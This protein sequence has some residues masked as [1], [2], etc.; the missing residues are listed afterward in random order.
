ME[1]NRYQKT[2][3]EW[4]QF[5]LET[6]D[7]NLFVAFWSDSKYVSARDGAGVEWLLNRSTT[8]RDIEAGDDGI[9][10]VHHSRLV[11]R[12]CIDSFVRIRPKDGQNGYGVVCV[13]GHDYR[14]ARSYWRSLVTSLGKHN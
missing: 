12:E 5:L 8:L 4:G 1:L 13:S 7:S 3:D 9:M 14:V 6:C 10:R 11:R 2:R